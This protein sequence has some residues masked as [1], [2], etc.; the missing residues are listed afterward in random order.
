MSLIPVDKSNQV[1]MYTNNHIGSISN[2]LIQS[3]AP[4]SE[5]PIDPK[6]DLL[7]PAYSSPLNDMKFGPPEQSVKRYFSLTVDDIDTFNKD[8]IKKW[9]KVYEKVLGYC[10]RKVREHALR[11]QNFCFFPVPEYL[12]GFPLYNITH[13]SCFIIKKLNQSGFNTKY[14]PPNVI[15]IYWNIKN[16]YDGIVTP[17][18]YQDKQL[19]YNNNN[20]QQPQKQ[21]QQLQQRQIN[22]KKED[23]NIHYIK[24]EPDKQSIPEEYDQSLQQKNFTNNN[25][26]AFQKEEQFLFG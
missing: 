3:F 4:R 12:A 1:S 20:N 14:I 26:Y 2:P 25:K 5:C 9:I 10:F 21:Q 6:N 7:P 13:C 11:D 18:N 22:L 23:K 19:R 16:Q 15:Y 24:L 8:K 17:Q